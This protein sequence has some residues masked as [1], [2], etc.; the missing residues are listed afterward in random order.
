MTDSAREL[1]RMDG[2]LRQYVGP[3]LADR[4]GADPSSPARGKEQEVSVLF[5]DLSGFTAF[6]EGRSATEVIDMLNAYWGAVVPFVVDGEGGLIERFAGD[7]ILAVFNA[8][9]DQPDHAARAP[10]VPPS[11]SATG[12]PTH[13]DPTTGPGSASG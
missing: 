4:L 1:A 5:A 8:L 10:C 13:G 9:G 6:A 12:P 2:L 7:A 11:R 3:Q